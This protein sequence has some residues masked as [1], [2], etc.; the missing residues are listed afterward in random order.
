[1]KMGIDVISWHGCNLQSSMSEGEFLGVMKLC[2]YKAA[3]EAMAPDNP[4]GVVIDVPTGEGPPTPISYP[5][6]VEAIQSLAGEA[7]DCEICLA[8]NSP[9]HRYITYPIDEMS[10]RFLFDYFLREL[11]TAD[12]PADQIYRDLI[13]GSAE[14]GPAWIRRGTAEDKTLEAAEPFRETLARYPGA[15]LDSSSVLGALLQD[16]HGLP[17]VTVHAL[18]WQGFSAFVPRVMASRWRSLEELT[19]LSGLFE[20]TFR[21]GIAGAHPCDV[22]FFP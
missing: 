21:L 7:G 4:H 1:M 2:A 17:A 13:A 9:G 5:E 6:L 15:V 8:P 14:P 10:E 16:V 19:S 12:T 20:L 11:M 22:L 3:A 18:F